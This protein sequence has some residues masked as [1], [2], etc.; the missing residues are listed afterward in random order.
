M[1]L[2][3][4]EYVEECPHVEIQLISAVEER[5]VSLQCHVREHML[6]F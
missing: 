1:D 5:D 6:L 3:P 4:L 2:L